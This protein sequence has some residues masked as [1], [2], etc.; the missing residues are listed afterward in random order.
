[1]ERAVKATWHRTAAF[2]YSNA[3]GCAASI[4]GRNAATFVYTPGIVLEAQPFGGPQLTMPTCRA[5]FQSNVC[6]CIEHPPG[7]PLIRGFP[8][9]AFG[10][11]FRFKGRR[12]SC[13]AELALSPPPP[14][15]T[16]RT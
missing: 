10:Q 13:A 5:A 14:P 11:L 9:F 7:L 4:H 15:L 2:F 8:K 6:L 16:P 1:M 12:Q 3:T